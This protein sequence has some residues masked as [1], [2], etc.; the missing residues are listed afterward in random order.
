MK[1]KHIVVLTGSGISAESGIPTFRSETGMWE[2]FKIEE[3]CVPEALARDRK[4]V[5]GFYNM[6]RRSMLSKEPNAAHVALSRLQEVFPNTDI[7]TQN[8]DNLHER[9]GNK[10]IIHLHGELTKLRSSVDETALV[11]LEGWEQDLSARHPDGSLLRPHIVFFGENVP[12]IEPAIMEA[13]TA[14]LFIVVGTSLVVYP[15]ASLLQF[16]PSH[17]PIYIVD[18]GNM[19]LPD[20]SGRIRHIKEKASVGLPRLVEQIIQDSTI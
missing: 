6:L 11:D 14:D 10:R 12:N 18:P 9:A 13:Q 1:N 7:I 17:A 4:K 19:N 20:K 5:V 15:A 2:N 8:V 16:V 3:V